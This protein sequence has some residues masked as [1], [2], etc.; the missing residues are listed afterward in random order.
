MCFF[1][2]FNQISIAYCMNFFLIIYIWFFYLEIESQFNRVFLNIKESNF[3]K[4]LVYVQMYSIWKKNLYFISICSWPLRKKEKTR[5]KKSDTW[6]A[7]QDPMSI[8]TC[9]TKYYKI[10]FGVMSCHKN[11]TILIKLNSENFTLCHE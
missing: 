9:I 1:C 5:I 2:R 8:L 3:L 4:K 7:Y 11:R 6:F 10:L